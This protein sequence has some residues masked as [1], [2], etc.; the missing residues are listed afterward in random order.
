MAELVLGPD[1]SPDDPVAVERWMARNGVVG[2]DASAVR[3]EVLRLSVYRELVR[4]RLRDAVTHAIPRTRARL[5]SVFDEYFARFLAERGP[6]SHYLRDV[7]TEFLDFVAPLLAGDTRVP[8]WALELARHEALD[9]IV[10]SAAEAKRTDALPELDP[11]RALSFSATA[12]IVR[13]AFAVHRVSAELADRSEPEE[14]ATALFVYRSPEHDVRYLELSPLAAALL[15]RLFAG[16]TLRRA[17]ERATRELGVPLDSTVLEG[18]ARVLADLAERGAL[19]GA[20]AADL[21]TT[22]EPAENGR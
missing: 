3:K 6:R 7:T 15:E 13:Y 5:G 17:L 20:R 4:A 1:V 18:S 21:Q 10:G 16:E 22:N 8:A 2:D 12:R 19:V 14:V 11:D 9:I